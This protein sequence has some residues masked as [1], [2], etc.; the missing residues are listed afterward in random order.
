MPL[1]RGDACQ[2]RMTEHGY[3][4]ACDH[5]QCLHVHGKGIDLHPID[6]VTG[7]GA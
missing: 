2:A 3:R 1:T 6:L 5:R 4:A 7:E